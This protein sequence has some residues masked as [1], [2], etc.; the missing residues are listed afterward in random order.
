MIIDDSSTIRKSAEI[1]LKS[2]GCE[3]IMAED[4]FEAMHKI[5]D[6]QPDIIFIDIV[7]P[8]LNGY[9]ACMLIKKN[10]VYQSIPVIMLSSKDLSLIQAK[11][12]IAGSD[13]YLTKP[14]S[15]EN[16][17]NIIQKYV[18]IA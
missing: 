1:F 7:M 5:V 9:Q 4:G 17:I 18:A 14:F 15:S 3:V 6:N 13:D 12:R 16:L 8:R 10:P 11:G 2:S